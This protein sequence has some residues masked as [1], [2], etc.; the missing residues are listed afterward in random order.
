MP[1]ILL[2]GSAHSFMCDPNDTVLGAGLRAG[3]GMPYECTAGACG[4]CKFELLEGSVDVLWDAAP[5]LS[6]RDRAKGR[7]LACQCR[8]TNDC[9]IK[10]RLDDA[11]RAAQPPRRQIATLMAT[12]DVTHDIRE[13]RFRT[14]APAVFRPGQFAVLQLPGIAG[15]RAYSM[16]NLPNDDGDWHFQVRRVERGA[17]SAML[18]DRVKPGERVMLD[19]PYGMAFLRPEPARDVVCVAG[20]SGL[21]PMLSI[22]RGMAHAGML[23]PRRLHF[24]YGARTPRDVCGDA[25]LRALPGYGEHLVFHPAVSSPDGADGWSGRTGFVHEYV[26]D[27]LG[28]RLADHEYYMAGPPPMIQAMQAVLHARHGVPVSQV[29]FDRFF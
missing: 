2:D 25:Q 8:P 27:V 20:G 4:T 19:G 16:A 10:V 6:A 3:L 11:C 18:F 22:A 21:A 23:G 9:R 5:G 17:G 14:D 24:F 28:A 12:D 1:E 7:Q 13:L 26:E 29:H 15:T